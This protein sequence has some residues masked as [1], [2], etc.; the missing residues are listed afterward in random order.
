MKMARS[1]AYKSKGVADG[2]AII[3]AAQGNYHGRTI[4]T[5]SMSTDPSA[6]NGYGPFLERVGAI[7][8]FNPSEF[9]IPFN[10]E[11]VLERA[12]KKH[13]NQVAA[14]IVEPIQGEGGIIVPSD[15]YLSKVSSLCKKHNVL[16]ICDEIQ[17]GLGRTG[18]L[19][20]H[21]YDGI[22]PDL[23]TLGK[24]LSGGMYPVS[25]VIGRRDVMLSIEPGTHG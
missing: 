9:A 15:G 25:C 12:F 14:F 19:S 21:E 1:W 6:R 16:L 22:K 7:C 5:I 18:K 23:M 20:A 13:G 8:P 2:K 10:N 17:T 11:S 24:S 4:A 3:L